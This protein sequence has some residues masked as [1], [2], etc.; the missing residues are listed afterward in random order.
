[1]NLIV[2][3][4]L[5]ELKKF[6]DN[7]FHS[8]VT[9]PPAAINFMNVKWDKDKGGRTKWIEWLTEIMTECHRVLK[10]GAHGFV[11]AIPRTSHWTA[12]ALEDA[13]FEIRDII[14]H[15]FGSG[16]PKSLN[17]SKAID[18]AAGVEREVVASDDPRSKFDGSKRKT[19]NHESYIKGGITKKESV[20][21]TAP[22]TPEAKQWDGW[23]TAL[24]PA[25][26]HWIL[27]RKPISEK[28]VAKN[29]IKWGVG[30]LNIDACRVEFSSE[31][32]RKGAIFGTQP[33]TTG[34]GTF[35]GY[36][37]G[38]NAKNVEPNPQ[39]RFPA[40]LILDDVAG[41]MLDAQ[42]GVLE[43]GGGCKRNKSPNLFRGKISHRDDHTE[44]KSSG[45]ASRFF[46]CAKPSKKER[47]EG[48][49]HPT[50]K[51]IK[52]LSYLCRL[53][54]PP[55]GT[56]LDPFMGSASVG[57]AAIYEGFN[58][59]GIDEDKNYVEISK[60]RLKAVR[61]EIMGQKT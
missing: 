60:R 18:K 16:F 31:K 55:K 27:I 14:T 23:G 11:W 42:S 35:Q 9:D 12:T 1:M 59:T 43:T 2:G 25:S 48:N 6:D 56:I 21:I 58:F 40:N 36:G 7:T 32:D 15:L 47:G 24:K 13:G 3:D 10:P 4:A 37:K 44:Y 50:V 30:G 41:E 8:L 46:Y 5:T 38:V 51:P 49:T 39:G 54:T 29:V 52:L 26:E 17:I 57:C 53:I 33:K 28:T 34:M 19:S 22:A 45:G 61:E 20:D